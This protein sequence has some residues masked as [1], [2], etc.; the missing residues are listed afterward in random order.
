[1]VGKAFAA[2]GAVLAEMRVARDAFATAHDRNP[3]FP[4]LIPGPATRGVL[5]THAHR[6]KPALAVPDAPTPTP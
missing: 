2:E 6:A 1:M 5:G 3:A 4:R